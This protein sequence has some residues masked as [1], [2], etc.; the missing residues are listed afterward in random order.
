MQRVVEQYFDDGY[1]LYF[2]MRSDIPIH[3]VPSLHFFNEDTVAINMHYWYNQH[4]GSNCNEMTATKAKH[5]QK[6]NQL[7]HNQN[8]LALLREQYGEFILETISSLDEVTLKPFDLITE[9]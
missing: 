1:D 5:F 3:D 2:R 6:C 8:E 9:L 7:Y 4:D